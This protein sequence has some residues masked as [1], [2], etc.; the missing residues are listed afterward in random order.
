M[1]NTTA[2]RTRCFIPHFFYHAILIQFLPLSLGINLAPGF[3]RRSTHLLCPSGA[4]VKFEKAREWGTPIVTVGWLEE[5]ARTGRLTTIAAF[6]VNSSRPV[7][8]GV[9]KGEAVMNMD[10][11]V[12]AGADLYETAVGDVIGKGKGKQKGTAPENQEVGNSPVDGVLYLPLLVQSDVSFKVNRHRYLDMT[13][14][15]LRKHHR[16]TIKVES[17]IYVFWRAERCPYPSTKPTTSC[18][19]A[20]LYESRQTSSGS[21]SATAHRTPRLKL[22]PIL[23]VSPIRSL[24]NPPLSRSTEREN[25]RGS[26]PPSLLHR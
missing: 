3:S 6:L 1:D 10:R 25:R 12:D 24:E 9:E 20:V 2:S 17:Q 5:I 11:P 8:G 19:I 7:E 21:A 26:R 16:Q 18:A 22:N 23:Q 15:W 14:L 4:G 13:R